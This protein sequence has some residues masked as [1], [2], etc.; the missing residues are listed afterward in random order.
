MYGYPH[1]YMRLRRGL[2]AWVQGIQAL[3]ADDRLHNFIRAIEAIT[4]PGR[5]GMTRAFVDRAQL[6]IG[7]STRKKSLLCQLYNL[8]S[9]IEHV[10]TW[11]K[12]LRVPRGFHRNQVFALRAFQAEAI[13][14]YI[15]LRI[16]ESPRLM[17]SLSTEAQ[18][19]HF[20]NMQAPDREHLWGLPLNLRQEQEQWFINT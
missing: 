18:F 9:C 19:N 8:R 15:Y 4:K 20:W 5:R 6:F 11:R 3:N 1:R 10:K 12:E 16:F 13:A 2:V 14:S 17:R 7:S